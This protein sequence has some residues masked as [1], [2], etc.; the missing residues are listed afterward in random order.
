MR[1]M[2]TRMMR[3]KGH[4]MGEG[5]AKQLARLAKASEERSRMQGRVS[6]Q[7]R[8]RQVTGDTQVP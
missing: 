5:R 6:V 2:R 3:L 1:V 4:G 7:P 8:K